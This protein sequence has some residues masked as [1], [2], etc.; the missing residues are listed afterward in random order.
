[1]RS[2]VGLLVAAVLSALAPPSAIAGV[3]PNATIVGTV[4]LTAVDG[5]TFPGEGARV[6]LTCPADGTTSTEVSNEH[7]AFRFRN[8]PMD[9]CSI[10]ADV[11]GFAAQPISLLTA[12]GQTAAL[13][14]QLGVAPVRV[15]LNVGRTVPFHESMMRSGACRSVRSSRPPA[16]RCKR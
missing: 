11:Q 15:G 13:D 16:K 2:V 3:S 4:T 1:M 8:V 6:T 9:S 5:S 12:A 14:L 10:Q 7:G